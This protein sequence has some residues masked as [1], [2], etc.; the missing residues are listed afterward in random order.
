MSGKYIHCSVQNAALFVD[1]FW[2]IDWFPMGI[3]GVDPGVL[4]EYSLSKVRA[5]RSPKD[6][7]ASSS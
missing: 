3:E 5:P 6:E 7:Y 1:I 4:G 2:L